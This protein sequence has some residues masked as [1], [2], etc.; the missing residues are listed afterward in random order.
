MRPLD[1]WPPLFRIYHVVS[2]LDIAVNIE[3]LAGFFDDHEDR[4]GT[5][6][7]EK[8]LLAELETAIVRR[9]K[10]NPKWRTLDAALALETPADSVAGGAPKEHAALY[11]VWE[12]ID[13]R[14]RSIK[15][16]F[17]GLTRGERLFHVL[18]FVMDSD[19]INGGLH[20]FFTNS[21]GDFAEEAKRG[22]NEIGANRVL[23]VLQKASAVLPGRVVPTERD[24]RYE[25][26]EQQEEREGEQ[27]WERWD[28]LSREYDQAAQEELHAR[29]LEWVRDHHEEFPDP[30]GARHSGNANDKMRGAKR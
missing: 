14:M 30:A 4:V 29:L 22:L 7:H 23:C 28:A 15:G 25:V 24:A 9:R 6:A 19:I 17:E 8:E 13:E 11:A 21:S 3:D 18:W 1:E 26:L 16:G 20:Q 10:Q 5:C 2:T 12:R 27:V